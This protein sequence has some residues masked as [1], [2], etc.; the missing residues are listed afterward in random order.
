LRVGLDS[1][2]EEALSQRRERN[3]ADAEL[4]EGR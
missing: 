1:S 2:G 4:F 3:E